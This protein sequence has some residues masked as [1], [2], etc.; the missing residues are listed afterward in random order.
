M[1]SK[2]NIITSRGNFL[3][4]IESAISISYRIPGVSILGLDHPWYGT[5]RLYHILF[6]NILI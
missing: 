5:V 1:G 2:N 4:D 6:R 3:H